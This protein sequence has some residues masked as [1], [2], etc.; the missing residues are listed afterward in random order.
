MPVNGREAG[1]RRSRRYR[2]TLEGVIDP[3]WSGWFAGMEI[4]SGQ[5]TQTGRVTVLTGV[6]PDQGALRGLLTRVW[7]LN[8]VLLSV[9]QIDPPVLLSTA[10]GNEDEKQ[11]RDGS[12]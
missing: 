7:D 1:P 4:V 5:E 11:P 10:Q 9:Q 8:L 6:I 12:V 2:V 3:S